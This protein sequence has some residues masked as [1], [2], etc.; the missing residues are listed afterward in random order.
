MSKRNV[1]FS[2]LLTTLLSSCVFK[3][4]IFVSLKNYYGLATKK[5]G[6]VVS[7]FGNNG[8]ISLRYGG[9]DE[10]MGGNFKPLESLCIDDASC[11]IHLRLST[12]GKDLLVKILN[13]GEI[14]P[15]FGSYEGRYFLDNEFREQSGLISWELVGKD[16]DNKIYLSDLNR[17]MRILP[18]GQRDASFGQN[19]VVTLDRTLQNFVP[20]SLLK[21]S[22]NELIFYSLTRPG[23]SSFSN[24][25]FGTALISLNKSGVLTNS[26]ELSNQ[27]ILAHEGYNSYGI[28]SSLL[29]PLVEDEAGT[30]VYYTVGVNSV[31]TALKIVKKDF[32]NQSIAGFNFN[33]GLSYAISSTLDLK[34][35]FIQDDYLYIFLTSKNVNAVAARLVVVNKLTGAVDAGKSRFFTTAS[36]QPYAIEDVT[37]KN[38][39]FVLALKTC[40]DMNCLDVT[41]YLSEI[42]FDGA[43]VIAPVSVFSKTY[44]VG[45]LAGLNNSQLFKQGTNFYYANFSLTRNT[46]YLTSSALSVSKMDENFVLDTSFGVNGEKEQRMD[47]DFPVNLLMFD[48]NVVMDNQIN[49][50][51]LVS[52][53]HSSTNIN[54]IIKL[55]SNVQ[56][57]SSFATNGIL[58]IENSI[59]VNSIQLDKAK[60]FLYLSYTDF[61]GG[62]ASVYL[63]RYSATTGLLDS[64]FGSGTGRVLLFQSLNNSVINGFTSYYGN[65]ILKRKKRFPTLSYADDNKMIFAFYDILGGTGFSM[66]QIDFETETVSSHQK[67]MIDLPGFD[68]DKAFVEL[69]DFKV[70]PNTQKVVVNFKYRSIS[71]NK[72]SSALAVF[73]QNDL[74]LLTSAGNNNDGIIYVPETEVTSSGLESHVKQKTVFKI[75]ENYIFLLRVDQYVKLNSAGTEYEQFLMKYYYERLDYSGENDVD[76]SNYVQNVFQAYENTLSIK[77]STL[78]FYVLQT[79]AVF[80][81]DSMMSFL[82]VDGGANT[83]ADFMNLDT[84]NIN[85]LWAKVYLN[86][87]GA[88]ESSSSK[89]ISYQ[90]YLNSLQSQEGLVIGNE[91]YSFERA[92]YDY[93]ISSSGVDDYQHPVYSLYKINK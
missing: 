68:A 17:I 72:H 20:I 66:V 23:G 85:V 18:N 24:V 29:A 10:E 42:D 55:D 86:S 34:K 30:L 83:F 75:T 59:D 8:G 37:I 28:V 52:Y 54:K 2:L 25:N 50:Y 56:K 65:Q 5:T 90:T 71:T 76:F 41:K 64:S 19:G 21:T 38:D 44:P 33:G 62:H 31:G 11:F 81:S 26:A 61:S 39:G 80:H 57:V 77:K 84:Q 36:T 73:N 1:L 45:Q 74:S 22:S 15:S 88:I 58:N 51:Y 49:S 9:L 35:V 82:F 89:L 87:T 14:D 4:G 6:L 79:S 47:Y 70:F 12:I 32:E 67:D 60:N 63:R 16:E 3:E 43:D 7:D 78:P 92:G 46:P 91:K 93:K 53:Y 27:N 69:I 48:D 13:N 40:P